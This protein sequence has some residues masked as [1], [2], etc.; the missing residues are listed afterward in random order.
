MD[1][2]KV[3]CRSGGGFDR[4]QVKF[5]LNVQIVGVWR[6]WTSRCILK[7]VRAKIAT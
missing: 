5:N 2:D 4:C 6:R 3:E 7:D 1:C